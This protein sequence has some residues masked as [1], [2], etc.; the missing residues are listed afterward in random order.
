MAG[1]VTLDDLKACS[2]PAGALAG[3]DFGVQQ[4]A[5]DDRWDYALGFIGDA[6][7]L[8]IAPPYPPVL[9]RMVCQLAAFDLICTRGFNPAKTGDAVVQ[10]RAENAEKWLVR[11]ANKQVTLNVNQ[12]TPASDQPSIDSNEPRGFGDITGDG[13]TDT[14]RV[15]V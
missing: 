6:A 1:E 14:P 8:P 3:V 10:M 15:L 9:V 13:A 5:L 2:L 4:R 12:T 11:V 7:T